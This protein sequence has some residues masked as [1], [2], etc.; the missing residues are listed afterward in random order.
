MVLSDLRM[1]GMSGYE[2]QQA[3]QKEMQKNIPFMFMTA[4]PDEETESKGFENGAMDFIRKP[5]RPDVLLRRVGNILQTVDQ[6]EIRFVCSLAPGG[7]K[8]IIPNDHD[9]FRNS[10]PL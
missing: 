9:A 1:P 6:F 5:F 10:D 4:D 7:I 3:L 2:L 8:L